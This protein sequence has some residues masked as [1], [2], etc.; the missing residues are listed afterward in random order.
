MLTSLKKATECAETLKKEV[1]YDKQDDKERLFH[2]IK[3][4]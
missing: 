3:G 2:S 1:Q 4:Y